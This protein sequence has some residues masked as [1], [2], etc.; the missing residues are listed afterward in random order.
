MSKA[1]T[2]LVGKDV[3]VVI[4]ELKTSGSATGIAQF[5]VHASHKIWAEE[6]L[7]F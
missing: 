2:D 4:K 5:D 7:S 3:N 1:L 6:E